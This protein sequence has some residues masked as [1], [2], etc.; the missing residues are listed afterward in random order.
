MMIECDY[1]VT[2][3]LF[4]NP[5]HSMHND[6]FRDFYQLSVIAAEAMI[7]L[8]NVGHVEVH[9]TDNLIA[10]LHYVVFRGVCDT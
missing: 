9:H 6:I 10:V 5:P 7:L 3:R 8:A 1:S 4:A 2:S